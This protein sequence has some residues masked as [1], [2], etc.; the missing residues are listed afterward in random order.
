MIDEKSLK[1]MLDNPNYIQ[2][3]IY[4][5]IHKST[6]GEEIIVSP[7]T[8]F[9]TLVEGMALAAA[10][11]ITGVRSILTSKY[12]SLGLTNQELLAH[13]PD[14]A[15]MNIHSTPVETK[16]VFYINLNDFRSHGY[17]P[18]NSNYIETRLLT[19]TEVVV[20]GTTFTLLND[21]V[22]RLYDTTNVIHATQINNDNPI[23]INNVSVVKAG[24]VS[25][26][27]GGSWI[28]LEVPIKQVKKHTVVSTITSA[29]GYSRKIILGSKY[30]YSNVSFKN[31]DY[32]EG[33]VLPKSYTEEYIDPNVPRVCIKVTGNE[34]NYTIPDIYLVNR[35]ISGELIIDIY[36]T[37]GKLQLP[38]SKYSI[39]NFKVSSP[40]K[41]TTESGATI[42][43]IMLL[44]SSRV[45]ASGGSNGMSLDEIKS[46]IINNTLGNS[47]VPITTKQIEQQ[48][49]IDGFTI[50]LNTDIV[51]DRVLIAEKS[52]TPSDNPAI[53]TKP[54]IY[55]NHTQIILS[56]LTGSSNVSMSGSYIVIKGGTIFSN[57]NGVIKV[58]CDA[59]R[60]KIHMLSGNDKITYLKNNKLFVSPYYY[61]LDTNNTSYSRS[62]VYDLDRPEARDIKIVEVN[63]NDHMIQ[64]NTNQY[65]LIKTSSGYTLKSTVVGNDAFASSDMKK[66]HAQ[67]SLP[68]NNY[69]YVHIPG[70]FNPNTG[71]F[72]FDIETDHYVT[73]DDK[74]IITNGISD[75]T[76][77]AVELLS[78]ARLTLF[79][80]DNSIKD[81]NAGVTKNVVTVPNLSDVTEYTTEIIELKFGSRID[82]LWDRTYITYTDRKYKRHE[83]DVPAT[84]PENV[85]EVDGK[86][87]A[88]FKIENGVVT[89]NLIHAAGEV[90]RDDKGDVVLLHKAGDPV[91]VDGEPVIDIAAGVVYNIDI[92]MIEYEYYVSTQITQ[93]NYLKSVLDI[94]DAWV[95]Q[96][97][98]NINKRMLENTKILYKSFKDVSSVKALVNGEIVMLPYSVSP[99]VVL[100]TTNTEFTRTERLVMSRTI[101]RIIHKHLD[102]L[103]INTAEM[104]K[105]ILEA[106]GA[107]ISAVTV[108]NIVPGDV[109]G[110]LKILDKNSR[111]ALGKKLVS[112]NNELVPMYDIDLKI[113]T[114]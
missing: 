87:G 21:V 25:F 78:K 72:S 74:L 95:T 55:F 84:Y 23:S 113:H 45:M 48:G 104:N 90:V 3:H 4:E 64:V 43:N 57:N 56:E 100:Y 11:T 59:E 80:T 60:D 51:T 7:H 35:N 47:K 27:D 94:I 101:G 106:L 68:V 29:E 103:E 52:L 81:I 88:I 69:S 85:Y 89:H 112:I 91:L 9:S 5:L 10:G 8:P 107:N 86:T 97:L 44:A 42:K 111:L 70:T 34:V 110:V 36:E 75:I 105:E 50:Y 19:D 58:V 33:R 14:A 26:Q 31:S 79:T 77:P 32:P 17:R 96:E 66:F 40:S 108:K 114:T 71:M 82:Y 93:V 54:D 12:P 109:A 99:T 15:M 37:E 102:N 63:N 53:Y 38:L 41:A 62:R 61:I 28:A 1:N 65:G 18:P 6:N 92:M 13:V 16:M 67:L 76:D 22:V 2:K 39:D 20:L 73:E 30:Y 83:H 24:I 98:P 46:G 49:L